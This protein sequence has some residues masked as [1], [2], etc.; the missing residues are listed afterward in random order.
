M[1][2]LSTGKV[3]IGELARMSGRESLESAD[4]RHDEAHGSSVH[5]Y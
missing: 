3:I 5:V 2:G 4:F 1:Q